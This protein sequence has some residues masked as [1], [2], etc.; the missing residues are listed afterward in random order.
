MPSGTHFHPYETG[1][2]LALALTARTK[3]D[4]KMNPFLDPAALSSPSLMRHPPGAQLPQHRRL[5]AHR[6]LPGPGAI[7]PQTKRATRSE[8]QIEQLDPELLFCFEV[9][10]DQTV[11]RFGA[12]HAP[13]YPPNPQNA[14]QKTKNIVYDLIYMRVHNIGS[15]SS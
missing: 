13:F 8:R 11:M 15:I 4:R 12:R 6:H 3:H 2:R 14:R 1:C 7:D 9:S 10:N 5:T